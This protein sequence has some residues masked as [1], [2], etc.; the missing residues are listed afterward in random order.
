MSR[1]IDAA[2]AAI[3]YAVVTGQKHRESV[4]LLLLYGNV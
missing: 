2:V 3:E 1:G 4:D